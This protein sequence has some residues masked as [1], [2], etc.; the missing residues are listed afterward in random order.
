[1]TAAHHRQQQ[2]RDDLSDFEEILSQFEGQAGPGGGQQ[3]GSGAGASSGAMAPLTPT[4]SSTFLAVPTM[5]PHSTPRRS[6]LPAS[7]N[8]LEDLTLYSDNE[9]ITSRRSHDD[10][11][12]ASAV[13]AAAAAAMPGYPHS[14]QP[15]DPAA[16]LLRVPSPFMDSAYLATSPAFSPTMPATGATTP[17]SQAAF[18]PWGMTP[19]ASSST[20]LALPVLPALPGAQALSDDFNNTH[21]AAEPG[22]E[23]EF[24][25]DDHADANDQHPPQRSAAVHP[26][27][28]RHPGL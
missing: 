6:S 4:A 10:R 18:S 5:L 24:V 3:R 14:P 12:H 27:V 8:G 9:E 13:A 11:R 19:Q 22:Y 20:S 26:L 15:H 23:S 25:G 28:R 17:N 2:Q 1:R 21:G 16:L 7:L